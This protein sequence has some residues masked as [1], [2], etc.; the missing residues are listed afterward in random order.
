MSTTDL[1]S[2]N[3]RDLISPDG[4]S[5][6]DR[7]APYIDW[8]AKKQLRSSFAKWQVLRALNI[9]IYRSIVNWHLRD[10]R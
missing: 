4:L 9:A 1:F 6:R 5:P 10:S 3:T 8:L 2:A 7:W